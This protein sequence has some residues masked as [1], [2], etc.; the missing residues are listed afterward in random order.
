MDNIP[1][2]PDGHGKK[3]NSGLHLTI[4]ATAGAGLLAIGVPL[5]YLLRQRANQTLLRE[6]PP[7]RTASQSTTPL[8]SASTSRVTAAEAP[9]M[10]SRPIIQQTQSVKVDDFNGALHSA[11]AF[12]LATLL[13]TT[14]ATATIY[15]IKT[16]MGVQSTEEFAHRM[17]AILLAKLPSLSERIH[18]LP[19][20]EDDDGGQELDAPTVSTWNWPDAEQRLK[21]IFEKD[22]F[23]AWG[24]AAARELEI[25]GRLERSKRFG[26]DLAD[27]SSVSNTSS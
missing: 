2:S 14:S 11:K 18:R 6:A 13:V 7:R 23:A 12:G 21:A 10:P 26:S 3:R 22:G 1:A 5:V 25:E 24:K 16:W 15:G 4:V 9:A 20:P 17:R 27:N 19:D 8:V